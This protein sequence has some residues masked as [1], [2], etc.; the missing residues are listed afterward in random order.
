MRSSASSANH[1]TTVS[2]QAAWE[3]GA[4]QL[5]IERAWPW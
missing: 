5:R 3:R 4:P 2:D 1:L